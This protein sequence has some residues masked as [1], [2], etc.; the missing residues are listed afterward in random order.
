MVI[1]SNPQNVCRLWI[2]RGEKFKNSIKIKDTLYIF[3][4]KN[5]D[6]ASAFVL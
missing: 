5:I 6:E 3:F 4:E 1:H 2:N